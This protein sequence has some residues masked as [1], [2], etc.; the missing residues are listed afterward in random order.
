MKVF[1]AV[2]LWAGVCIAQSEREMSTVAVPL[3]V[4]IAEAQRNNPE[5]QA[6][7]H[8]YKAAGHL[9]GQAGALPDTQVRVQNLSVGS[10]KP[11]AGY[12]NSDFAYIGLG[13]SQEFPWP[14][15]RKLRAEVAQLQAGALQTQAE[16]VSRTVT[17]RV[18]TA[19][20]RLAY[21]QATLEI[22]RNNDKL[23]GEI[24]QI[25]ESRYRVG[26]GNQQEVLK[27]QLQHTR[28]L[29]EI[30]MHHRAEAQLQ[31]QL[32]ALLGRE[33]ESPDVATEPSRERSLPANSGELLK[34][35]R[36]RNPEIGTHEQLI[37]KADKQI[38]LA[39]KEFRPDLG[40]EY[41]Y[42]NTDR[43][44]R[45]YYMLT[46]SVTL[47]NRGRRQAELSEALEN[48]KAAE[49]ELTATVQQRLAEVQDQYV[50]AKFSAEQLK[51]YREGLLPQAEATYRAALAAYEANRQD[52]QTLLSSL[53]DVL[54]FR[55]QYQKELSEHEIAL[56][57]L[58]SLTGVTLP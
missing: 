35:A 14:G 26:R 22:L 51:I 4:L 52:F 18:K 23:L 39:H 19:Y 36:E 53:R 6:A 45:D 47:P 15:K 16:S 29:Q 11:F 54:D 7:A 40:F 17:E 48:R 58:E 27:A 31:A 49:S 34:A 21:L 50:A 10:P 2:F 24:E 8:G 56:T 30:T 43:K 9:A 37:K 41:M 42:Q 12:T 32:K 44:F 28:I 38:E 57:R 25:A 5:I 46:F 20:F 55:E 1:L 13:A 3:S 33:Q